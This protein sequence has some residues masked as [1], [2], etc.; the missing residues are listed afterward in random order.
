M[1]SGPTIETPLITVVSPAT[2]PSQFPPRSAAK[3]TIT[4]PGAIA[5]IIA[6]VTRIGAF[7]PGMLAVVITMSMSLITLIIN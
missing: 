4:D 6:L 1:L 3:S 7:F 2:V 5:A